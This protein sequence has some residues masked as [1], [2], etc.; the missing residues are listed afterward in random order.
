MGRQRLPS[1]QK[2]EIEKSVLSMITICD[3][4]FGY[5]KSIYFLPPL[6]A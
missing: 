6:P 5:D 1:A 2:Y 3:A 4:F